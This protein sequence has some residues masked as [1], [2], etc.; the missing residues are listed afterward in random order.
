MA[1]VCSI[2]DYAQIA[3]IDAL[4]DVP[5][6]DAVTNAHLR[7]VMGNKTDA[8]VGAV[9]VNKSN[10][11]YIKG[12]IQLLDQLKT[13]KTAKADTINSGWQDIVNITDKGV[14]TGVSGLFYIG[15]TVDGHG[16][17]KIIIDGI[18]VGENIFI[19]AVD[20]TEDRA[21]AIGISFFHRFNT[22]LQVQHQITATGARLYTVV[23]YTTD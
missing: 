17:I 10:I 18:T 5:V 12:L 22:S 21:T 15:G 9:G 16:E 3:V 6:A 20:F 23:T 14:L 7:D 1:N 4:H 8:L 2:S 11:A 19:S 13:P